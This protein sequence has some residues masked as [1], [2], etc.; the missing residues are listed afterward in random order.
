VAP[1]APSFLLDRP[2]DLRQ[3]TPWHRYAHH[4]RELP[5]RLERLA[6]ELRVPER[7]R[8]LDYGCAD[9]PYRHFFGP[10]VEFVAADLPGNPHATLELNPDSTVPAADASFDAV[11]STQVLEHVDDPQRYLAECFRVLRPDGRM[12][13][14]THGTFSY[15]PDPVDYWRWTCAGLRRI[16]AAEGFEVERFEGII[17][18]GATGLQLF[19]ESIYYRA[20]RP[21]RP[22]IAAVIQALMALADRFEPAELREMNGSVFALVARRP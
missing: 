5:A 16:V 18:M 3:A 15:H 2:R 8:V 1:E 11:L 7:G 10:E 13:L 4:I 21:L 6:P 19:Q 12:L 14:S 22:V 17:G 9:A 20:P